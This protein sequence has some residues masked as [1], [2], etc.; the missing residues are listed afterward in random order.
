[1]RFSLENMLSIYLDILEVALRDLTDLTV[2]HAKLL[3]FTALVRFKQPPEE[4]EVGDDGNRRPFSIFFILQFPNQP[5]E[6]LAPL[7]KLFHALQL[8]ERVRV[9]AV[10]F[11][12]LDVRELFSCLGLC[13]RAP[14]QGMS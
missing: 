5:Q 4:D 10:R 6:L 14:V 12:E 8:R 1:M 2:L 11:I 13:Q 9:R 3:S 7:V